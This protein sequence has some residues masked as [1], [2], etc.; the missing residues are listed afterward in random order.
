[1]VRTIPIVPDTPAALSTT[2]DC[3]F[4]EAFALMVIGD[5]MQPEFED[6]DVVVIEPEGLAREGSFVLAFRNGEWIFRQ[7][8]ANHGK[9]LLHSI[10]PAYPDL[11]I[12][13][14]ECV[15]GVII[16]KS[17]PGSRRSVKSYV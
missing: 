5:S 14:L 13:N 9:W 6:G 17:K 8:V 11:P 3:S 2:G 16:Q 4:A 7:L 15:R 12:A 10:N 1:M